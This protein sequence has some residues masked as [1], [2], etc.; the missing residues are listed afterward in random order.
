MGCIEIHIDDFK[1][2]VVT[3]DT[4]CSLVTEFADNSLRVMI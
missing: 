2:K 1:N 4:I 3:R